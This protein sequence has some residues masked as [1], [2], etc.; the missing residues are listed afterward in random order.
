MANK[1][2][3][4]GTDKKA[5]KGKEGWGKCKICGATP[6]EVV[7]IG[8]GKFKRLCCEKAGKEK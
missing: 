4:A 3:N 5:I 6:P 7:M 2:S 1:P 8:P